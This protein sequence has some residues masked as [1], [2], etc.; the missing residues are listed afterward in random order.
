MNHE[1][2]RVVRRVPVFEFVVTAGIPAAEAENRLRLACASQNPEAAY[3][4]PRWIGYDDRLFGNVAGRVFTLTTG[5]GAG[6]RAPGPVILGYIVPESEVASSVFVRV[7]NPHWWSLIWSG[8]S[9]VCLW[10]GLAEAG[11]VQGRLGMAVVAAGACIFGTIGWQI[12]EGNRIRRYF[13]EILW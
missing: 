12:V 13:G 4:L 7:R 3:P 11:S 6:G 10:V 8:F 5:R 2:T 1:N 9:L